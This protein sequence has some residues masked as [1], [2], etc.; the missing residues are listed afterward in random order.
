MKQLLI[1]SFFAIFLTFSA[2]GPKLYTALNKAAAT[3][4]HNIIAILPPMV[5]IKGRRSV[6][7]YSQATSKS[8]LL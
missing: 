8:S 4:V 2:C 1:F 6:F 7:H 3:A 5:S